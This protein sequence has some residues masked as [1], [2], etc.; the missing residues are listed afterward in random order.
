MLA[1]PK[2]NNLS[3]AMM[4]TPLAFLASVSFAQPAPSGSMLSAQ[5]SASQEGGGVAGGQV[6][7]QAAVAPSA[8]PWNAPPVAP[9][10]PS[11]VQASAVPASSQEKVNAG[12]LTT[13]A[14]VNQDAQAAASQPTPGVPLPGS[15]S[16]ATSGSARPNVLV[17]DNIAAA[18]YGAK[19]GTSD[20]T[21]T[22]VLE[23]SYVLSSDERTV[24]L[25]YRAPEQ[26]PAFL[27]SMPESADLRLML[28]GR[29]MDAAEESRSQVARYFS[30][31]LGNASAERGR[32]AESVD[33]W[34]NDATTKLRNLG[35]DPWKRY[36][37]IREARELAV[38][39]RSG[40]ESQSSAE[41]ERLTSAAA[42]TIRKAQV[43]MDSS[44]THEQKMAWYNVMVQ[45]RD[46]VNLLQGQILAADKKTVNALTRFLEGMREEPRPAGD[47]P[48]KVKPLSAANQRQNMDMPTPAVIRTP[49]SPAP[50][51]EPPQSAFAKYG[52][53]GVGL[54]MVFGMLGLGRKFFKRGP[55]KIKT[56]K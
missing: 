56:E 31:V 47:P 1:N 21:G 34:I 29:V 25:R 52:A 5:I 17:A 36:Q 48:T 32:Q 2:L 26:F 18:G 54:L 3:A 4:L 13:P 14:A 42:A 44:R 46:G 22:S 39:F 7:S 6:P 16:V 19:P 11:S 12:A 51:A 40:I 45:V 53:F 30:D 8:R 50:V 23:L 49:A 38:N 37:F 41:I 55:E 27:V 43:A 15:A 9:P 20:A 35:P 10:Q 24:P 33:F 28:P